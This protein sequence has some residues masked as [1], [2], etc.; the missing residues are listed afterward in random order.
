[1]TTVQDTHAFCKGLFQETGILL[2]PS[3]TFQ[4]DDHHVRIGFGRENLPTVLARF[5]KYLDRYLGIK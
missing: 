1:M 5:A 3:A 4:F 2:V